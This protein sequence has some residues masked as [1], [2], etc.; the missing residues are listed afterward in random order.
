MRAKW[1]ERVG[2]V[3]TAAFWFAFVGLLGNFVG[4]PLVTGEWSRR[5]TVVVTAF[6][7]TGGV[8]LALAAALAAARGDR[9]RRLLV[10]VVAAVALVSIA[11]LA[12]MLLDAW[13]AVALL[14]I[15]A[16]VLALAHSDN[17]DE[18]VDLAPR[19]EWEIQQAELEARDR[20]RRDEPTPYGW[21]AIPIP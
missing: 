4:W 15:W 13:L 12:S 1:R 14:A 16:T 2:E 11:V 18:D 20:V 17:D 6:A 3:M 9:Q 5:E 19:S 10:A 21:R 7:L 8:L